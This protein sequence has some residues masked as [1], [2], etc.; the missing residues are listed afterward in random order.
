[1]QIDCFLDTNILIYAAAG[2]DS[3]QR[4]FQIAYDLVLGR[5]FGVSGQTLAEFYVN[6]TRKTSP[7][8][9]RAEVYG[10]IDVLERHPFIPVDASLVR[11]GMFL[12][13]R[14]GISYWDGAIIAATERLG[15]DTLFTE[16]LNH[17]QTY[18]SVRVVDP[19]REVDEVTR[20]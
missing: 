2:R 11:A 6:I 19:F 15:A 20:C 10:W 13:Q 16:D 9:S 17:G 14:Y 3:D 8:P 18:G 5:R 1:M 4:K 12:S 7:P